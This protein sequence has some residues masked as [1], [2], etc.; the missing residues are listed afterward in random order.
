MLKRKN[1][2][3]QSPRRSAP[4]KRRVVTDT[5]TR[6]TR[7]TFGSSPKEHRRRYSA[8]A[9]R[10]QGWAEALDASLARGDCG[11]ATGALVEFSAAVGRADAEARGAGSG[12]AAVAREQLAQ[13]RGRFARVCLAP[14]RGHGRPRRG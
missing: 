10:T 13:A 4:K 2:R 12:V 3:K 5:R 6:V 11:G 14:R 1:K 9:G 8:A 7:T